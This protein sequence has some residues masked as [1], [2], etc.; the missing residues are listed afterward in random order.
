MRIKLCEP[1]AKAL[2][3]RGGQRFSVGV[4]PEHFKL[5]PKGQGDFDVK[6]DVIEHIGTEHLIYIF[7]PQ[8]KQIVIKTTDLPNGKDLSLTLIPEK[9]HLF[10][11]GGLRI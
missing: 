4:R 11:E 10:D 3:D 1:I 8:D 7:L 6:I 5:G 2:L 9:T